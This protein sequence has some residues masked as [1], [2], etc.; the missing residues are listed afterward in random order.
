VSWEQDRDDFLVRVAYLVLNYNIPP[1]LLLNMD[2]T[3]LKHLACIGKTWALKNSKNVSV[4][5]GKDKRQ[6]TG[7]PW[8]NMLGEIIY[9]HTTVKGKTT[10]CLPKQDFRSREEFKKIIFGF[11]DNHWV[12]H[13]TMKVQVEAVEIYRKQVVA[14]KGLHQDQKMVILWDVYCKHCAPELLDHILKE[15]YPH[16]IILFIPAN[17][18]EIA[19]PLDMYFNGQFKMFL[20]EIRNIRI[21]ELFFT[22]KKRSGSTYSCTAAGSRDKGC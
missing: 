19:Q 13:D 15:V 16:I 5:G 22:H 9:F 7:T 10:K 18:T 8:L 6:A 17:L 4:Q 12:T 1:E 21:A 3:P 14:E 2:E 20:A 11:S